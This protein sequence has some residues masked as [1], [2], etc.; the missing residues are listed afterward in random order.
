MKEITCNYLIEYNLNISILNQDFEK[1]KFFDILI[2]NK[3]IEFNDKD[4]RLL[5]NKKFIEEKI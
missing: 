4:D 1:P 3:A 5:N 2:D